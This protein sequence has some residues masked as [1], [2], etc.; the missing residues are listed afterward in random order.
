MS[1]I[2]IPI[3][4]GRVVEHTE[5]VLT[6]P[7]PPPKRSWR[8]KYRD[9]NKVDPPPSKPP[10]HSRPNRKSEWEQ[11]AS[12]PGYKEYRRYSF[13][14]SRKYGKPGKVK[15]QIEG[16]N[17]IQLAEL[18]DEARTQA[19]KDMENIKKNI[20]V[21]E[22]AEEALTGALTVLRAPSTQQTKL[23]AAKLILEFTRSKPVAK[24]EVSVN[25][26]EEWL[27]SL[28]HDDLTD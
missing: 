9:P 20:E 14:A 11:Y 16:Y 2:L 22:M 21:N 4:D 24:S 19:K 13:L 26:A 10:S 27:A 3:G 5:G 7:P 17:L 23:Q 15:G 25:K 1:K 12:I 6:N 18:M 8:R 28:A